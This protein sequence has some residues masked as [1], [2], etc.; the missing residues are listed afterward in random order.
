MSDVKSD[1]LLGAIVCA[2]VGPAKIADLTVN[3]AA[4]EIGIESQGSSKEIQARVS[5]WIVNVPNIAEDVSFVAR[6]SQWRQVF[7]AV[8]RAIG[9]EK[10]V[11]GSILRAYTGAVPECVESGRRHVIARCRIVV[12]TQIPVNLAHH[13]GRSFMP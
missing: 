12:C 13:G 10:L 2:I 7:G 6:A 3:V 11:D 5:V 4:I 1:R 9:A 8:S